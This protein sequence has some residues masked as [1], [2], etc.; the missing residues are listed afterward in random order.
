MFPSRSQ[1]FGRQ[2]P[3]AFAATAAGGAVGAGARWSVGV[4]FDSH[5]GS[6]LGSGPGSWPWA[7]LTVNLVGCILI[8]IAAR[9]LVH[10]SI[11]WDFLVTG[12]L[13]GFTTMSTLATDL[14]QLVD[15]D[16]PGLAAVY[17]VATVAGGLGAV[18][19]STGSGPATHRAPS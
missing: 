12:V 4:A 8:G 14:N 10:G 6:R 5:L 17:L 1:L 16:R 15:A 13:G 18:A 3:L 9:R 2:L 7:T 19:L 11:R